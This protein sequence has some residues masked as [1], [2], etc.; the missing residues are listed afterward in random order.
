MGPLYKITTTGG[1]KLPEV[2]SALQKAIRRG[3]V[4]DALYWAT[5]MYQTGYAEYCWKRLRIITSEDVGLADLDMPQ[6]IAAL[7]QFWLD[8]KKKKDTTHEPE[9][10]FLVH[11][12]I[13][14]AQAP[15]SRLV[16]DALT[17][18][19]GFH[20]HASYRRDIPDYALDRHTQRGK[21]MGRGVDHVFEVGYHLENQVGENPY[22]DC[23]YEI[24]L[25]FEHGKT[26]KKPRPAYPAQGTFLK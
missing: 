10:M 3:N 19:W 20:T 16:D 14:L 17:A 23:A 12:V 4:D 9:R 22:R 18:H 25:A 24:E 1:H 6:R 5:D 11:A 2:V 7:Y 15:K 21:Q 13:L 26:P 8:Q